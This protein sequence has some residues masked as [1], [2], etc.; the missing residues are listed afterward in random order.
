MDRL[1]NKVSA[2]S[3]KQRH[4]TIAAYKNYI[5][6]NKIRLPQELKKRRVHFIQ[7]YLDTHKQNT[8]DKNIKELSKY[9]LFISQRTIE[10][11]IF[12][13]NEQTSR[14]DSVQD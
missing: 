12:N 8:L 14:A 1:I 7:W 2:I 4:K 3:D 13:S 11:L 5:K 9:Y 6:E 10:V